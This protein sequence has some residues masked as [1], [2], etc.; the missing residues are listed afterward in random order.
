MEWRHEVGLGKALLRPLLLVLPDLQV[1]L[2]QFELLFVG[3]GRPG[4]ESVVLPH[5][6]FHGLQDLFVYWEL[7]EAYH[8][9]VLSHRVDLVRLLALGRDAFNG[10]SGA[11]VDLVACP[12]LV[13]RSHL[14]SVLETP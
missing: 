1:L 3:L 5:G 14:H 12:E 6:F 11:V 2:V 4:F 13:A 9:L 10:S 7:L 8:P